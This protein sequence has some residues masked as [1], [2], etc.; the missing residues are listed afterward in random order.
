MV[1]NEEGSVV[2]GDILMLN[3]TVPEK[4]GNF[5]LNSFS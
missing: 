1:R 2:C 3:R 5:P 4:L